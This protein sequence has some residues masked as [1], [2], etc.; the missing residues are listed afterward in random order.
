VARSEDESVREAVAAHP[1]TPAEVLEALAA[2]AEWAVRETVAKRSEVS[3][4]TLKRLGKDEDSSVRE[5]A[6]ANPRYPRFS[7]LKTLFGG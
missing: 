1:R 4:E 3:P 6:R 5:A 2:D 7:L